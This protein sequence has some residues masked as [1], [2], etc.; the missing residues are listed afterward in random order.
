MKVHRFQYDD[1]RIW[2]GGNFISDW[3]ESINIDKFKDV[4]LEELPSEDQPIALDRAPLKLYWS[5][6]VSSYRGYSQSI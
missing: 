1:L 2:T 4:N 3:N 6:I 5:T